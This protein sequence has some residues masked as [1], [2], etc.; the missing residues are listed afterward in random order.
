M[1]IFIDRRYHRTP[2]NICKV[3]DVAKKEKKKK[4]VGVTKA[5]GS[6][7][8]SAFQVRPEGSKG[9]ANVEERNGSAGAGDWAR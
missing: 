3:A 2:R 8:S 6:R 4:M 7:R 1:K 9:E 5:A